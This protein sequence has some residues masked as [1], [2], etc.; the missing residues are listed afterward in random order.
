MSREHPPQAPRSALRIHWGGRALRERFDFAVGSR[1]RPS[2]DAPLL[3]LCARPIVLHVRDFAFRPGGPIYGL[4]HALRGRRVDILLSPSWNLARRRRIERLI[5]LRRRL[6]RMGDIRITF[7]ATDAAE[8]AHLQGAGLPALHVNNAAFLDERIF[9]P[10]PER[11][12][13]FD[14]VYDA[15]LS[16]FKRHP[17]AA[18]VPNLALITYLFDAQVD[19]DYRAAV[20]PIVARSHVFNGDPFRNLYRRLSTREVNE[21]LN[22]CAVGLA[23]SR[24]EGAMYASMQYLMAGLPVVSTPSEGGRADFYHPD[25]VRIVDPEPRAVADAVAELRECKLSAEEIHARSMAI[26]RVHRQRLFRCV[27]EIYAEQGLRRSFEA[28]WP[29]VFVNQLL[30]GSEEPVPGVLAAIRAAHAA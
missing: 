12:K 20:E 23:L 26:A 30:S 7:F 29:A 6:Q 11:H 24:E 2:S 28:E 13:K 3:L 25:Y 18:Q 9:R 19:P 1:L 27:D 8:L 22:Q 17:L 15:R 5:R 21:C 10:L 16:R 14:A 4:L